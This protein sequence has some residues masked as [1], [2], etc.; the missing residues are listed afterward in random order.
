M[1]YKKIYDD[2]ILKSRNRIL[3]E[4]YE[5]HHILPKCI[6]GTDDDANIAT[7]T[8]EEHYIGHQ[9]LVKIYP[10]NNKLIWA[11]TMMIP[12]RPHNKLYGWLKRKL[13][14]AQSHSQSGKGNSQYNKRWI[15]NNELK[16]SK[17]IRK[18]DPLPSGWNEG[19]RIRFDSLNKK[20][21]LAHEKAEVAAS[22]LKQLEH[23]HSI[24]IKEGFEGVK[25]A[26][27][28]YSKANLV[29]CFARNLSYFIPQNGKPR[30]S[31]N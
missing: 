25:K 1:N 22:K 8:P 16:V 31:A 13:S 6:G 23:L 10:N 15:Y 30:K 5:R 3:T 27:Y 29:A 18:E 28:E 14:E 12:N 2:L 24:Y 19:R 20:E 7:L 21:L 11:A 9:L 26:G 4:C 17:R